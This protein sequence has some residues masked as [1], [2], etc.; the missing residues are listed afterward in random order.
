MKI[1]HLK[2]THIGIGNL[3]NLVGKKASIK[4]IIL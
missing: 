2:I 4:L 1:E 3:T